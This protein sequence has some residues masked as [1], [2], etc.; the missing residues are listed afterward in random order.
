MHSD[1][2]ESEQA[3]ILLG[4]VV[5]MQG[6]GNALLS[7]PQPQELAVTCFAAA[8]TL[9]VALHC[10]F[11][12]IAQ[13]NLYISNDQDANQDTVMGTYNYAKINHVVGYS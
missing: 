1:Q 7:W 2:T 10:V 4:K 8:S 13:M 5:K 11:C 9:L 3:C 6:Q 12:L